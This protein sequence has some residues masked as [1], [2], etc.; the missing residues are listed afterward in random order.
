MELKPILKPSDPETNSTEVE[1][2]PVQGEQ[3]LNLPPEEDY[4]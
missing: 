1:D 3:V 4:I 2:E